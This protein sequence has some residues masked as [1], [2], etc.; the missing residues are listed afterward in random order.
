MTRRSKLVGWTIFNLINLG[1][2]IYAVAMG[3]P[4]HAAIHV[5]L[6]AAGAYVMWRLAPSVDQRELPGARETAAS[7]DHLQESVDA[8]ALEVERIS[9]AQRFEAKLL[10]ERIQKSALK[11]DQ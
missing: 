4:L 11:K 2:F 1:G 6:L 3:E 5:V 9:E 8:I 10:N 7:L